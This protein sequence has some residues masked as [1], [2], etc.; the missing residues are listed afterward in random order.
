MADNRRTQQIGRREVDLWRETQIAT[1][2]ALVERLET[3]LAAMR[4]DRPGY[5]LTATEWA[6]RLATIVA[7]YRGTR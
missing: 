3:L 5:H 4:T 6:D 1:F 2:E 7:T